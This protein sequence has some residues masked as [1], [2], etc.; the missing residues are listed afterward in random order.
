MP[1]PVLIASNSLVS[2]LT[3]AK[4]ETTCA[5]AARKSN[6]AGSGKMMKFDPSSGSCFS[7]TG[8]IAVNYPLDGLTPNTG[9]NSGLLT[10]TELLHHGKRKFAKVPHKREKI[11]VAV[12]IKRMIIT[13]EK[14]GGVPNCMI[15]VDICIKGT[16]GKCCLVPDITIDSTEDKD[17]PADQMG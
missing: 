12:Q 13:T 9:E 14:A 6:P 1:F 4:S 10:N 3:S 2:N 8:K 11:A 15:S 7:Y 17:V 16:L 5:I